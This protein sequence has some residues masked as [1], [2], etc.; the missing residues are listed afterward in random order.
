MASKYQS[1][2][3]LMATIAGIPFLDEVTRARATHLG[4]RLALREVMDDVFAGFGD[5]HDFG[6]RFT[7]P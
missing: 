3:Q 1:L 6:R 5:D 4:E 7:G 2:I